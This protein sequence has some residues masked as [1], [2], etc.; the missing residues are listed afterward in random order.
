MTMCLLMS[1]DL[2]STQ[3]APAESSTT[4]CLKRRNLSNVFSTRSH[5]ALV[6]HARFQCP[7]TDNHH[8]ITGRIH[9]Q[10][11]G[12]DLAHALTAHTQRASS[13]RGAHL[14]VRLAA[15]WAASFTAGA[16]KT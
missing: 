2:S 8:Q 7:D 9:A 13:Q 16:A 3:V 4:R 10:P 1:N 11:S 12:V 5:S 14:F 6:G 15:C